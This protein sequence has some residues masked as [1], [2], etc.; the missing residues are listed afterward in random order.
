MNRTTAKL[1]FLAET[2]QY[3]DRRDKVSRLDTTANSRR[4][5]FWQIVTLSLLVVGYTGCYLCRSNFSVSLNLIAESLVERG[6]DPANARQSLAKIASYGVL[7]YAI[8]KFVTGSLAD[9]LGGRRNVLGGMLGSVGFT[10]L[11][12]VGGS[13]PLFSMAWV[14]NRLVQSLCWTGMVKVTGHGSR[15]PATARRWPW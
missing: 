1:R 4:L 6:A 7:A 13:V 5:R 3:F 15:I 9:F 10:L 14:G 12:A 2:H 8:G 11:F